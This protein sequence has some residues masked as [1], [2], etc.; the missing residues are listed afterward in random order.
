M[1]DY[2]EFKSVGEIVDYAK[3]HHDV[4]FPTWYRGQADIDWDLTPKVWRPPSRAG[5]R[6]EERV[7]ATFM[8]RAR[9][10]HAHLPDANEAGAWLALMQHYGAPTRLLDW[11]ESPLVAAFF[12]VT[13][14]KGA[15]KDGAIFALFPRALNRE[16]FN[17]DGI[18]SLGRP[19][20]FIMEPFGGQVAFPGLPPINYKIAAVVGD[21][22]DRRQL[23]QQSTFT[24]HSFDCAN[25]LI[26]PEVDRVVQRLRIPKGLKPEIEV[27]LTSLGIIRSALFPDLQALGDELLDH[28]R[29]GRM[30]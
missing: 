14:E 12:A 17:G 9:S 10:R 21:E 1:E 25:L 29:R 27:E 5:R 3:K 2:G 28:L 20:R 22:V 15:D 16:D 11:T 26:H 13:E 8:A 19:P 4:R 6:E 23:A 24:I 7:V 30:A 18:Y